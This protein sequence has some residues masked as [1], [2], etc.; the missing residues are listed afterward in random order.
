MAMVMNRSFKPYILLLLFLSVS[1]PGLAGDGARH[2]T[3]KLSAAGPKALS[4]GIKRGLAYLI[5]QQQED[6]GWSQGTE[7]SSM[8]RG[9]ENISNVANVGDTCMAGLAI[10]RAGNYPD[11]GEYSKNIRKAVNFVIGRVENADNNSLS[12]SDLKGTRIQMKLGPY[13]DTFLASLFLSEVKA[14][15]PDKES[16]KRLGAALDKVIAKMERNQGNDGK[17]AGGGWAPVHAQSI[18]TKGL[19]R[20]KQVGALVSDEVLAKAESYAKNSFNAKTGTFAAEGSANVPLYAAG[21]ALGGLQESINTNRQLAFDFQKTL[22]SKSS[23]EKDR[24]TAKV[25]LNRFAQTDE[26]QAQAVDAVV[27]RLGDAK[28]VQGFG[29]N[30]GEEFLSYLDISEALI[31][32]DK[33]RWQ[34]WNSKIGENINRIQN[35]D[36]SWMGQ[37]CITSKTFV[38]AAALLVLMVDRKSSPTMNKI[39]RI[40]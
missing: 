19:N 3:I 28:F 5:S 4:E 16:Q 35:E 18:A 24:E 11:T 40:G 29:C 31:A 26:A 9:M 38:T 13:I 21:A 23:S 2:N 33:A 37:H 25:Q 14:H 20:A 34:E 32:N 8:G 1:Q 27:G 22:K 36:G 17:W 7:S 30:G 10:I 12:V 6:G 39:R 15:M